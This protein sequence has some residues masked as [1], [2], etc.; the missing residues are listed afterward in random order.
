LVFAS[1]E[2]DG[3]RFS[4]AIPIKAPIPAELMPAQ[5]RV[6]SLP[7]FRDM[8]IFLVE[9]DQA[10]R[11]ALLEHLL[12]WG[13]YVI[14]G[15][16]ASEVVEK[17]R[18]EDIPT[19]RAEFILSDYRLKDGKTGIDAIAT[20]RAERKDRTIPAAIWTAE[21]G[22]EVLQEIAH[23]GI[24]LLSKPADLE[25]LIS[26]FDKADA[27]QGVGDPTRNI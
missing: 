12:D 17:S 8:V 16:S 1:Q 4:I 2:G 19:H 11:D 20:I 26:V 22:F 15:E 7:R 3:S 24:Q 10:T 21:S 13:C 23:Q 9:D 5:A 14:D 18:T 25:E 27:S 6:V